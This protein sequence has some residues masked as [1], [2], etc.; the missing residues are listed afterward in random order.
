MAS[1][2]PFGGYATALSTTLPH[3]TR[4]LDTFHVIKLGFTCVDDVR[5][6]VQQDTH[7][8]RGRTGDPLYGIRRVLRLGA[9]TLSGRVWDRLLIGL[10]AGDPDGQ[11]TAAWIAA[12]DLRLLYRAP[13]RNRAAHLLHRLLTHCADANVPELTRLARTLDAWRGEF[14]AVFDHPGISNGPTEAINLLIK[15]V[16]VLDLPGPGDATAAPRVGDCA[17]PDSKKISAP[18]AL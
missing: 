17:R 14:L 9:D 11:V 10:A 2:D 3:A 15:K 1:L 6:R 12:Q 8:H 7:G 16:P 13:D 18:S 5:R 4:V